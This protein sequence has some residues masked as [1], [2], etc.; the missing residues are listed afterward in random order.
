MYICY[1][2]ICT[3]KVLKVQNYAIPNYPFVFLIK[4]A[5]AMMLAKIVITNCLTTTFLLCFILYMHENGPYL[6]LTKLQNNRYKVQILFFVHQDMDLTFQEQFLAPKTFCNI[7]ISKKIVILICS[8]VFLTLIL[9]WQPLDWSMS[10]LP[11]VDLIRESCF[12]FSLP[13]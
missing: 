2:V 9:S 6:E 8:L 5:H 10:K 11:G 4:Y 3:S 7:M 1:T 13:I 12:F